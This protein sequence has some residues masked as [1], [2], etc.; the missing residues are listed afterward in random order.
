MAVDP[1]N[2]CRFALKVRIP[3]WA[4]NTLKLSLQDD[5]EEELL[6]ESGLIDRYGEK[7]PRDR[8]TAAA[9]KRQYPGQPEEGEREDNHPTR[10]RLTQ[11]EILR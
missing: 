1:E 6:D 4:Q 7:H 2:E 8:F 9:Q 11:A 5:P 10:G 3:G